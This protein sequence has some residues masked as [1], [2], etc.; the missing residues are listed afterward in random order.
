MDKITRQ[1]SIVNRQSIAY[2]LLP[3][4]YCLICLI[5][6]CGGSESAQIS[7]A[8]VVGNENIQLKKQIDDKDSQIKDLEQKIS[9][10]EAEKAKLKQDCGEINIKMMKLAAETEKRNRE[11]AAEIQALKEQLDTD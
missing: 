5:C 7:R 3:I 1:S 8:R 10:L 9:D 4:A 11:L 2:C 6:G